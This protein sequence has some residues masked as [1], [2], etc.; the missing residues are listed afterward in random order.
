MMNDDSLRIPN[1]LPRYV[2]ARQAHFHDHLPTFDALIRTHLSDF[3]HRFMS[4]NR[5]VM[6]LLSGQRLTCD[7]RL[8][9][10]WCFVSFSLLF[11][12]TTLLH[13]AQD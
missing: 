5:L 9:V 3:M 1:S 6:A 10:V 8:S 4:N 7:R 13:V 2:S 11:C 12:F